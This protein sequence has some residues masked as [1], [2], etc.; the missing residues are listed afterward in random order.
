[1]LKNFMLFFSLFTFT[2]YAEFV[3]D[4]DNEK[5]SDVETLETVLSV[6]PE[7]NT[8]SNYDKR[9][10]SGWFIDIKPSYF[11]FQDN[12][13]RDIYG[14]GAFM[15]TG[16]IDA[17]LYKYIHAFLD[18]SYLYKK[19]KVDIVDIHSS[20]TLVPISIGLRGIYQIKSYAAVYAKFGPNWIY[21]HTKQKYPYVKNSVSK[22]EIGFTCGIGSWFY[23]GR[24]F[25]LDLFADY[26][27]NKK[28]IVDNTS[29][30][31]LTRYLG[32]FQIGAG[33]AYKF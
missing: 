13:A 25:S 1:M 6:S 14:H 12:T 16:E 4:D 26:L 10:Y 31:K 32:G 11:I 27:Y 7:G 28:N 33:I 20:I 2:I 8:S 18:V 5:N 17:T 24:S 30:L 22:K 9:Y 19:G 21:A 23:L 15:I 3:E 29:N